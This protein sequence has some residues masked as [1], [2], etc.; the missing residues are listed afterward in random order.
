[1]DF[2]T[3]LKGVLKQIGGGNGFYYGLRINAQIA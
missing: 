3:A 2:G 1:M